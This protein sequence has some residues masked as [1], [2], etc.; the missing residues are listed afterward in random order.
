MNSDL[1]E[2]GQISFDTLLIPRSQLSESNRPFIQ[3]NTQ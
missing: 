1:F 3:S 2:G